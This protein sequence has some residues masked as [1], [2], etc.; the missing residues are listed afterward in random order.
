MDAECNPAT[1][2]VLRNIGNGFSSQDSFEAMRTEKVEGLTVTWVPLAGFPSPISGY[3]DYN[4]DQNYP[5]TRY[6]YD[7]QMRVEDDYTVEGQYEPVVTV[8]R[9]GIGARG[10]MRRNCWTPSSRLLCWARFELV[11]AHVLEA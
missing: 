1:L 8:M 2:T 11:G 6:Y 4:E 3:Y 7:G 9:Y 5:A 10:E